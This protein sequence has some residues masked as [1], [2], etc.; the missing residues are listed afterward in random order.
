MQR[1]GAA[2]LQD[3][4]YYI[5][6]KREKNCLYMHEQET[7]VSLALHVKMKNVDGVVKLY[8]DACFTNLRKS[9]ESRYVDFFF[10]VA[11][12]LVSFLSLSHPFQP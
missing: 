11:S 8:F 4:S 6:R 1:F 3:Q 2:Q 10:F 12:I 9:A 7:S 5:E